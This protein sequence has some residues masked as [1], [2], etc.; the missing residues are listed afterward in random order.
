MRPTP[1]RRWSRRLAA[2]AFVVIWMFPVYWMLVT[3][4]KP[5]GRILE[6]TPTFLPTHPSLGHFRQ[7]VSGQAFGTYL[8][9]SLM[10]TAITV[11][12][13]VALAFLA[14]AALTLYRFR[15]RRIIMMAVMAIQMIP[16]TALLIP[17]FVVFNR[18][19]MLDTYAGLILAY[20]ASILPFSIWNLRGFF[21]AMPREVFESARVEGAGEWQIMRHITLPLAAPGIISTSVF[22]FIHSWNDYV[23]AYTFMKNQAHYT[24]PVW[25]A[26]FSTPQGVDVGAQM[27][28]SILF[29]LP[30]IVFFLVV[31]RR[32][33]G[34]DLA[35]AIK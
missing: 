26:S 25:L 32:I 7:A 2:L 12:L 19:G 5:R 17:Q 22:A 9:N 20:M 14:C 31:Q 1:L 21:M 28:A 16:G 29:A 6:S 10:V 3:A 33:A 30:V 35:G 24:L 15:G 27:A 8:R 34:G 18:L 11:V 4:L 13:S 23:I